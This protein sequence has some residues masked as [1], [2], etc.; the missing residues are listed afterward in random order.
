MRKL[1]MII[2]VLLVLGGGGG[3]A[4]YY[5]VVMKNTENTE[6]G[7]EQGQKE[8]GKQEHGEEQG[9]SEF[10]EL[11]PLILPIVDN[12]GVS[13]VVSLVVAI[14]VPDQSSKDKVKAMSPK[15]KDAYI[16]DMYGM[17]N[18]QAAL[19]GGVV[20]VAMIKERLNKITADVMGKDVVGD[21]LLQVVQQRPI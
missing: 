7:E 8:A 11:D 6:A 12:S 21:V 18:Q 16:Q 10:V 19:K 15:L 4:Y 9:H 17:L 14:E 13:Q 3:G 1:L 20:Q 5:F 2:I